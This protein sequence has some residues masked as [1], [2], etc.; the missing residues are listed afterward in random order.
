MSAELRT[1]HTA[2]LTD[3]DRAA[4]RQLLDATFDNMTDAAFENALGGMHVLV[5]DTAIGAPGILVGHASVVQRRVVTA[6]DTLRAGYVEA[7]AVH[8]DHRRLGYGALMMAEL[9]R[10]IRSAYDLG[11]LGASP[12]GARLYSARGWQRWRGPSAALT[13]DGVRLTPDKDGWIYVLPA[14]RDLD[15]S[16]DLVCDW[17][18]GSLW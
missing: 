4:I 15:L 6:G 2:D 13:L 12:D 17:R 1:V 7:V 11:A 18:P 9:E 14:G 3:A 8:A 5:T 16:A 10:V